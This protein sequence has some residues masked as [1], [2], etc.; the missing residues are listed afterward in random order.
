MA[1]VVAVLLLLSCSGCTWIR[2]LDTLRKPEVQ[3]TPLSG[4]ERLLVV[5]TTTIV[6]DVVR[7]VAAGNAE[8]VVLMPPGTDPHSFEPLPE[9]LATLSRADVVFVNGLGL[10]Q[11][12]EEVL[13]STSA[14]TETVEVSAGVNTRTLGS[15]DSG[16]PDPHVWFD[17]HNV[18]TWSKNIAS[19]LSELD[20]ANAQVYRANAAVYNS[21]LEKLDSWI[22]S[23]VN[24]LPADRRNLIADHV[25]FGYFA[26]E[27][28]FRQLGTLV[29]GL[30]TL[31]EPN[32]K[33]LAQLSQ[34]LK[35]TEAGVILVGNNR[36]SELA[37]QLAA[38][39][40]LEVVHVYTG[41][42]SGPGGPAATY[43]DLMRHNVSLIVESL[44]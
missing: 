9:Q 21:Q 41:S 32:A 3:T 38:D 36:R 25:V 15:A 6:G 27:Y 33:R 16:V 12:L 13:T 14:E 11:A 40:D 4:Q 24:K 5:A 19:A 39:L 10:E 1:L 20:P 2:K 37:Q 17:P 22:C 44:R 29:G 42:L 34:R 43:I 35:E 23:E 31:S 30:S 7:C 26:E 18:M 28:G 8:I